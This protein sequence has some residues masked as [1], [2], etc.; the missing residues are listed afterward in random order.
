[1][2]K[3]LEVLKLNLAKETPFIQII[4]K[5]RYPLENDKMRKLKGLVAGGFLGGFLACLAIIGLSVFRQVKE[6]MEEREA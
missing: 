1:M 5:A 4:D 2:L 3:N 6:H